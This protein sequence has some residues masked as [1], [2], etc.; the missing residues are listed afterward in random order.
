MAAPKTGGVTAIQRF[1][2]AL[3]LNVHLH[4]VL[5]DGVF[6]LSGSG[7]ARFVALA[8]VKQSRWPSSPARAEPCSIAA[9]S[10]HGPLLAP[11]P[12]RCEP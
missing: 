6:D 4:T 8:G 1:D 11:L 5:P 12:L 9:G 7:P 10:D 2:G 3:N